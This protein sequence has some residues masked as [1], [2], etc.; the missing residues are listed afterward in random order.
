MDGSC[1]GAA[2]KKRTKLISKK[3]N[4]NNAGSLESKVS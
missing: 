2:S 3:R 4:E 1:S